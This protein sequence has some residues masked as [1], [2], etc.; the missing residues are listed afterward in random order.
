MAEY[1]KNPF[2]ASGATQVDEVSKTLEEIIIL[3]LSWEEIEI[4]VGLRDTEGK[5]ILE[6]GQ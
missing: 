6:Q 4:K 5:A 3:G 2:D 1:E